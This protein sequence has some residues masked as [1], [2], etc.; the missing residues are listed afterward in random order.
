MQSS[1]TAKNKSIKTK[2]THI[3]L[4][5]QISV[6]TLVYIICVAP[7]VLWMVISLVNLAEPYVN[8]YASQNFYLFAMLAIAWNS[9][10]NPIIYYT[11]N[12]E[13]RKGFRKIMNLKKIKFYS[14]TISV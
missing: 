7:V 13:I 9:C 6:L 1:N 11:K 8:N 3:R 10:F 5:K 14:N 2:K 12:P 4:A